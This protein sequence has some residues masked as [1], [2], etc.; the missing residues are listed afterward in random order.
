MNQ[1]LEQFMAYFLGVVCAW[2]LWNVLDDQG[3]Y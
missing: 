1:D 2:V 3:D